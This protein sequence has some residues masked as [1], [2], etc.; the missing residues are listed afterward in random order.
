MLCRAPSATSCASPT[1]KS[2]SAPITPSLWTP[3]L[4]SSRAAPCSACTPT[5]V[6]DGPRLQQSGQ[7]FPEGNAP[8]RG[9]HQQ[10]DYPRQVLRPTVA[11]GV[12][13]VG[14]LAPNPEGEP[15][16]DRR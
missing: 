15:Q 13:I 4:W 11:V 12:A 2:A 14:G 6:V 1:D 7:P 10:D 9:D 16:R 5:Q 8:C 3:L